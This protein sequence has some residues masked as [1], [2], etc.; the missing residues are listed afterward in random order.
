MDENIDNCVFMTLISA[1]FKNLIKRCM[2]LKPKERLSAEEALVI[3]SK[4][5][6]A[7]PSDPKTAEIVMTRM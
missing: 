5:I 6:K 4:D 7:I 2:R 3:L 1:D